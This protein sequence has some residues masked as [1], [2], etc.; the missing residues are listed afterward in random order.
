MQSMIWAIG[1]MGVLMLIISFLPLG[2]TLKGKLLVVLTSFLLSLC[3]L[4]AVS[5]LPLWET[6]L[7][8]FAL[9]F[10]AAYFMNKRFGTILLIGNS[11]FKE[12]NDDNDEFLNNE[13]SH[14]IEIREEEN[15]VEIDEHLSLPVSLNLEKAIVSEV[16]PS[17][18]M[19]ELEGEKS[20]IHETPNEDIS[21]FLER[22]FEENLTS[23][24]DDKNFKD[25]YL[26]DIESLIDFE[27]AKEVIFEVRNDSS[28]KEIE[29]VSE[30][31]ASD[32]EPLD[33]TLFDFL[34][35][36]KEVAAVRETE[37]V[38]TKEKISLQK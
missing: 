32:E 20:R 14:K 5:I 35:A 15:L 21:L 33:D 22:E 2:Y 27:T 23:E 3:G 12:L 16:N 6:A 34:L 8:L 28:L 17:L 30:Q 38:K 36:S 26:S 4:A 10:F 19:L 24:M 18:V 31:I 1:S 7:I 25:D 37:E 13:L 9:V 11:E 29:K